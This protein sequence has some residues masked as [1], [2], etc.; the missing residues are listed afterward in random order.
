MICFLLSRYESLLFYIVL[1]LLAKA[2]W[3]IHSRPKRVEFYFH[4]STVPCCQHISMRCFCQE[5]Y[6]DWNC[7]QLRWFVWNFI[8]W[9][10]FSIDFCWLMAV[11]YI[12]FF[13]RHRYRFW[14]RIHYPL[15]QFL[16]VALWVLRFTHNLRILRA[17]SSFLSLS[18]CKC[19]PLDVLR[20]LLWSWFFDKRCLHRAWCR[21][22][23]L[24]V[25]GL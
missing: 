1:A 6:Y 8:Y 21:L 11:H 4:S 15:L 23:N 16:T 10:I 24:M 12:F 14:I 17:S 5:R 3:G 19:C 13:S 2:G 9:V 18:V 7:F 22:T 25:V 20:I